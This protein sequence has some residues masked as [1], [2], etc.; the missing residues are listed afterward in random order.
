M[1]N[2]QERTGPVGT[3]E[4]GEIISLTIPEGTVY[5]NGSCMVLKVE[6]ELLHLDVPAS[7]VI[8]RL[9]PSNGVPQPG[10][11]WSDADG[12]A[13]F[14]TTVKVN[15]GWSGSQVQLVNAAGT[16]GRWQSVNEQHGPLRLAHRPVEPKPTQDDHPA[17]YG[18]NLGPTADMPEPTPAHGELTYHLSSDPASTSYTCHCNRVFAGADARAKF[19]AHLAAPVAVSPERVSM[20][21]ATEL[22][23]QLND[24][25]SPAAADAHLR[26]APEFGRVLN[27]DEH[28]RVFDAELVDGSTVT[29]SAD[30]GW[31]WSR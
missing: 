17:D 30:N 27:A 9:V 13:W 29:N 24:F 10:D 23:N 20:R 15:N 12:T 14:A 18:P 16:N 19:E 5:Y 31:M 3:Y 4:S 22:C 7:A 25:P 2:D 8:T 21:S 6:G 1:S 11:I 26:S 28:G